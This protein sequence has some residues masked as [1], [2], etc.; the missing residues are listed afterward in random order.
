MKSKNQLITVTKGYLFLIGLDLQIIHLFTFLQNFKKMPS[1]WSSYGK[2]FC[3][4]KCGT[5]FFYGK[6]FRY[7]GL[8]TFVKTLNLGNSSSIGKFLKFSLICNHAYLRTL[9]EYLKG[10][11]CAL[12]RDRYGGGIAASF[13]GALAFSLTSKARPLQSCRNRGPLQILVYQLT[14]FQPEGSRLCQPYY[15]L[16]PGFSDL[17]TALF[18]VTLYRHGEICVYVYQASILLYIAILGLYSF[19]I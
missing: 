15:Y 6:Y 11:C 2:V 5:Q 4:S 10:L 7:L 17:P 9:T 16:P 13:K 18:F 14:L 1:G 19:N 3:E 8:K 12:L